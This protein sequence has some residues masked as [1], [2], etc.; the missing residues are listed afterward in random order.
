MS[1]RGIRKTKKPGLDR[2]ALKR[3]LAYVRPYRRF[4]YASVLCALASA[5]CAL[6]IPVWSGRAIDG[7]AG[8]GK[9]DMGQVGQAL[10]LIG[11]A[12]A[13]S[14]AAQRGL[15]LSNNT[16][17]YSI[18]REMRTQAMDKLHRLP[19]SYLDAHPS[20]D[21]VS[22]MIS[23][24][25]TLT[26]GLLMGLT[27]LFTGVVTILGTLGIMLALDARIALAVVVL[28][29]LSLFMAGFIA[30][31]THRYFTD[32]AEARGRETAL[33]NEM[34]EGQKVV[35]AFGYE[36]EAL[37]EFDAVNEQLREVSM[38]A[39]FFSSLTNPSTRLVN[40]VIYAAVCGFA[41]YLCIDGSITV[42]EMSVFLSYASQY[43]KPFNE[44]SGVIAE[45]QNAL[46]CASRVFELLDEKDQTP[47]PENAPA[48]D[49]EGKVEIEDVS[50]SYVPDK[51]L[52]E[53][54]T[55]TVEKGKRVAIVG[56]TG[57]GKTTM[58]NLLMRFYDVDR[59]R[60]RVDGRDILTLTRHTLRS[61]Y[62]MVLQETWL[63]SGTVRE[64]IAYGRPDATE[65]EIVAAARAAHCHSFIRRLPQ[66]YDTVLGEN[67]GS[68]SQG[69][70]QLLCIA[71]VMLVRPPMLI[72]DEATS[73]ID[74]RT[75]V[76]IQE[77]F[78]RLMK[79]RTSFIVAHRLSTIR[80]ADTILVMRDG[81]IAE[82]GDHDALLAKNGVYAE[83][84]KSQFSG[85]AT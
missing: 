11:L 31:R 44:I 60:I 43:A 73:S 64:N 56:P 42:G 48:L 14:S 21:L 38:K 1:G 30:S 74:T 24:V 7:M 80:D 34:M 15:A 69:Q 58:I 54:F 17:T 82:Q 46:A 25:D 59:G 50:F 65:E 16:I 26:D 81:H 2:A 77:A 66:G 19:L 35:R 71:R 55:L 32:Q 36:E 79:G 67:G 78:L 40:N 23:D 37:K 45:L 9:A 61:N 62:G 13:L 84:Y 70:K 83:L 47:D 6:L 53:H 85:V 8:V 10:L 27:Q 75:E 76:L 4:L 5:A 20:G 41:A 51:K 18:A 22:R 28:T 3:L 39:T 29:P 49:A 72:L 52:I 57:C 68:L 63:K 12:A 33:I